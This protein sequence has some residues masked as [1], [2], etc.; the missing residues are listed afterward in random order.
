MKALLFAV[1]L[2][3][4]LLAL[5]ALAQ[6]GPAG[7][8]GAPGLA[9]PPPPPAVV[10][11]TPAPAPAKPT[12]APPKCGKSKSGKASQACPPK[13]KPAASNCSSSADPARCEQY[14]KTRELC[15]NLAQN[16]YRQ[17]LRDNLGTPK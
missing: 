8:P 15:R 13:K 1:S 10:V 4:T 3:A 14:R 5:P 9:P 2:T 11:S 16:E 12:A 7:V 6:Q 17:C